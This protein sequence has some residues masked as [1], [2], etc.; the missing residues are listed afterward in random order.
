MNITSL[1]KSVKVVRK[2]RKVVGRGDG[3]GH[4]GTSCR[5]HRGQKARSGFSRRPYFEGGQMPLIRRLPKRG[6]SNVRFQDKIAIVNLRDLNRFND[7]TEVT[8][9]ILTEQG[10]V[11]GHY[12]K[13]KILGKGELTRKLTIRA[14]SFS[15][16]VLEKVA[17][18]GGTCQTI[19]SG[20]VKGGIT[21]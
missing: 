1:K 11:K 2:Y 16:N 5:G 13:I 20:P 15:K 10:L 7:G 17:Q 19:Q 18:L 12:D 8:P 3:S 4:G 21:K 9:E 6:F 14:H